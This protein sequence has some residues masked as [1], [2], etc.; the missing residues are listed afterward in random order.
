MILEQ[1]SCKNNLC[2]FKLNYFDIHFQ[3]T[4]SQ[5]QKI[6]ESNDANRAKAE[7][8]LD[9]LLSFQLYFGLRLFY[10]VFTTV[11]QVS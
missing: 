8:L 11:E 9:K 5:L 4:V 1:F 6:S 10:D 3:V 7:D 2:N